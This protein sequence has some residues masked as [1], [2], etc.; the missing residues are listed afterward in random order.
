MPLTP[1]EF[2]KHLKIVEVR[3]FS[4][5]PV[6]QEFVDIHAQDLARYGLQ[7][8]N[9]ENWFDDYF[10]QLFELLASTLPPRVATSLRERVAVGCVDNLEVN[11]CIIRSSCGSCYAI[12]INRA[13]LTMLNHCLKLIG[14]ANH[15]SAVLHFNGLP[16]DPTGVPAATARLAL[17]CSRTTARPV[18]PWD[19]N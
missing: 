15:P 3:T 18:S 5:A 1:G 2:L 6:S 10:N 14:A 12:L 16:I 17:Q 4:G 7:D 9:P 19:Q 13:L 11:A 8:L